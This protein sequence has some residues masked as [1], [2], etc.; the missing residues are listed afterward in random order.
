MNEKDEWVSPWLLAKTLK[1]EELPK[2]T[3]AERYLTAMFN[4]GEA[5]I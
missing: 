4:C 2:Q 3:D 5:L 1:A